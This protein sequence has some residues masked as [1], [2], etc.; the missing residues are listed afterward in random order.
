MASGGIK[1]A[2][3]PPFATRDGKPVS[4]AETKGGSFDFPKENTGS[5]AKTGG[6]D[7][8]QENRPQVAGKLPPGLPNTDTIPAGGKVL[9]ADPGPVSRS[10][11]AGGI[12][13]GIKPPRGPYK[14]LKG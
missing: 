1:D 9:L 7:F 11:K 8:T 14:N 4:P 10:A 6:R 3:S 2:A 13:S 12:A 5:G